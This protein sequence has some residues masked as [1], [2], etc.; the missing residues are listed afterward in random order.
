MVVR[1]RTVA[2]AK[3]LHRRCHGY[4]V[5]ASALNAIKG[6]I[7]IDLRSMS[8]GFLHKDLALMIITL[9]RLCATRLVRKD[10]NELH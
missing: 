1:E 2:A 6:S 10:Q 3:H 7:I 8:I 9:S 5:D 4:V